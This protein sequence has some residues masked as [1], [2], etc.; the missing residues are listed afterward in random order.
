MAVLALVTGLG[1]ALLL[2]TG[3]GQN[4]P[5]VSGV[6]ATLARGRH[7][8]AQYCASCHGTEL[9]GQPNWRQR[10]PDGRLPAP[11]HDATGHTW[12]HSDAQLFELTKRGPAGLVPGYASDMPAFS[13]VLDDDEIHAVLL[14]IKSTWPAD[15]RARQEALGAAGQQ[16]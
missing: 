12:H 15:I 6:T 8:Y 4:Q 14:F 10:R 3:D 11:P 13:D 1:V 2:A 7:L 16:R 5:G 9:E